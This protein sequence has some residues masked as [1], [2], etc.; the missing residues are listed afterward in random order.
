MSTTTSPRHS[1]LLAQLLPPF[2]RTLGGFPGTA[3]QL[4]CLPDCLGLDRAEVTETTQMWT[5]YSNIQARD[6]LS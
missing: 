6:V 4:R 5:H 2:S 3:V 1:N